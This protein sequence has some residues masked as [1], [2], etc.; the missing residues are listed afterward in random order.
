MINKLTDIGAFSEGTCEEEG[1]VTCWDSS[2][3]ATE[4]DCPQQGP[5]PDEI[6]EEITPSFDECNYACTPQQTCIDG[7]CIDSSGL[8]DEYMCPDGQAWNGEA[9]VPDLPGGQQDYI[10]PDNCPAGTVSDQGGGCYGVN[11]DTGGVFCTGLC[12]IG[13]QILDTTGVLDNIL[14]GL[15]WDTTTEVCSSQQLA[16]G[17]YSKTISYCPSN[18]GNVGSWFGMDCPGGYGAQSATVC[19]CS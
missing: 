2:C 19:Q 8:P 6:Q 11:P 17:C 7:V 4:A 16:Q 14:E 1:N 3:A 9:C 5:D 18:W 15:G 12:A 13:M 10:E